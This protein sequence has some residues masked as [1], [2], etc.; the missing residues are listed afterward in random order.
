MKLIVELEAANATTCF[1]KIMLQLIVM[2]WLSNIVLSSLSKTKSEKKN[3]LS[4]KTKN[5]LKMSNIDPNS[6]R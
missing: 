1:N 4:K 5:M 6:E 2:F 3:I